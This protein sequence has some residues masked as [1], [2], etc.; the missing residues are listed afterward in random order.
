VFIGPS[1]VAM[2]TLG[3]KRSSK[4]YLKKFAPDVPLIP[5]FSGS[6]QDSAD[7]EKA[8]IQIGFPIML[9]ASAGGGGKGMRIVREASALRSELETAQSEA[10]RS[11]GSGDCI[12]E[13]YIE[14]GKHVEFQIVGDSH[15]KV[16]SFWDRDC[17]VQRRHQKVIEETPCPWLTADMRRRMSDTAVRITELIGYEGAGTVEFVVD[18]QAEKFY[19]LEVNARLQVEHPITEEVTGIDLVS[20]Q[21]FVASGGRLVDIPS[22]GEVGQDGHAIEVRLCAEDAHRDFFPEHGTI[23]LWHPAP[24]VLGPGRDIRYETA[25]QNG[26]KVSIHFDSMIAKLIVWAPTRSQAIEKILRVLANTVCAGVRTNQLFLQSCLLH[27][28]FRNPAYTT[29]FIPNN[30]PRLLQSP[31]K[32]G[33]VEKELLS[34]VPV[35]HLRALRSKGGNVRPFGNIHAGFRNQRFDPVNRNVNVVSVIAEGQKHGVDQLVTW[36]NLNYSS[37]KF[38]VNTTIIPSAPDASQGDKDSAAKAVT[39]RYNAISAILRN[40]TVDSSPAVEVAIEQVIDIPS[41]LSHSQSSVVTASFNSHRVI[42]I[43]TT[44]LFYNDSSSSQSSLPINVFAHTPSLGTWSEYKVY[45]VL[46]Y[47]EALRS[48]SVSSLGAGSKSVKAPM[49]CKVLRVLKQEGDEVTE[50]ESVIVVE[51]MKMEMNIA[52]QASGKFKSRVAIGDAVD[53]GVV[54]CEVH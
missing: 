52:I 19:F 12:L 24:G 36:K 10:Q 32:K 2:S 46:S 34:I 28:E 18:V 25:V 5:G 9:K 23:Q 50:G 48:E 41:T 29:S 35:L 16:I 4:A 15:G 3:N 14:A 47:A 33:K 1:S 37:Q 27:P 38:T 8:A 30:L 54:L 20:L 22:L 42:L 13:K 40:G 21:L 53:E 26:G 39:T 49:P 45:S 6:S 51:S 43:L 44:P 11:F 17:S 7:L 31:Y